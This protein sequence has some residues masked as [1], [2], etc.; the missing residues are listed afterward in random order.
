MAVGV[1][2]AAV[3]VTFTDSETILR[4]SGSVFWNEWSRLGCLQV[5]KI[6][7]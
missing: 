7:D 3:G 4:R 6:S 2:C 1:Q 5:R